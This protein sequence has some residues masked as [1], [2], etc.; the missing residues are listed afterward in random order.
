MRECRTSGACGRCPGMGIPTS[1][2]SRLAEVSHQCR[3]MLGGGEAV[4]ADAA[5]RGS[6]AMEIRGCLYRLVR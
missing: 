5:S 3:T 6:Q 4:V 1:I 2:A